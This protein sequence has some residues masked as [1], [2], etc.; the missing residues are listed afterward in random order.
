LGFELFTCKS[1]LY[2]QP[3]LTLSEWKDINNSK[4][5]LSGTL[6]VRC[7]YISGLLK[8]VAAELANYKLDFV[9]VEEFRLKKLGTEW[10]VDFSF[11]F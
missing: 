11:F 5:T 9:V 1:A 10:A 6:K 4:Q 3:G 2:K 7:P 8:E